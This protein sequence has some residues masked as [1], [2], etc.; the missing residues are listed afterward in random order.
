MSQLV[1]RLLPQPLVPTEN[2]TPVSA[3]KTDHYGNAAMQSVIF[4]NGLTS[5]IVTVGNVTYIGEAAPGSLFTE[6][7]WRVTRLEDVGGAGTTFETK[8]AYVPAS[9]VLPAK[10]SGFDHIFNNY[11]TLAYA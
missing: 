5:K 8:H 6:P 3:E 2:F 9:G 7:K 1:G 10:Y 11:A 4:G